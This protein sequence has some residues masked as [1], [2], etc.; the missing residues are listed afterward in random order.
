MRLIVRAVSLAVAIVLLPTVLSAEARKSVLLVFDEDNDLPGLAVINQSLRETFRSQLE[1]QVEFYSESL[2]LSQFPDPRH[3][4]VVRDFVRRKYAGTR[5]DL[6]VAVMAP[7][8][9]F[10]LRHGDALFPGVPIVFCGIDPTDVARR[11][12]PPNVTG[13]LVKRTFAPTL[14]IARR[15]QPDVRQV[16][17]V[18]GTSSF[19]RYVQAIARRELERPDVSIT[20]LTESPMADLLGRLSSL[21]P[22]S[23]VL[24]LTFF[25]DGTGR[26]F[27]PHEALSLITAAANAPVYVALD[28]YVGRGAVGGHVYSLDAHGQVAAEIGSRVLRGEP[29]ASIP[30]V[31]AGTYRDMFDWRQL[32]RWELDERRLPPGSVVSFRTRSV[33]DAYKWYI[34]GSA[35]LLLVQSALIVGL[36]VSRAQRRRAQRTLAERLQF[37]TLLSELSAELLTLPSAA[38]DRRIEDMLQRVV[39]TLDFDRAALAERIDGTNSMRVT[40]A[41]TRPGVMPV[42]TMVV[43][44][45]TL[46]W[47]GA[48][49]AAGEAVRISRV[50]ALPPEAASDRQSLAERG[51][52]SLAAV[53]LIV[54]GAVVGAVGFSRLRGEWAWPD[55]LMARLQLLGDVF[56]NVLARRRAESAVRDSEAR[57]RHAE[58]EARRQRDELAH[59]QRVATLGELMASIAHEINQPLA[60]ILTNANATRRLMANDDAKPRD[61]DEALLDIAHDAKR[62]AE[63]IRRLRALFL[64]ERAERAM[65]GINALIEEV[66]GLLRGDLLAKNIRVSFTAGMLPPLVADP[67]QLRQVVLNVV[68]NAAEAIAV[69]AEG[70]REMSIETSQPGTGRI[71]VAIRD[72]GVG[73]DEGKLEQI[74]EHFVSTKPEGLGMGLAISRSIVEAHGGR[75]WATCNSDRGLTIHIELPCDPASATD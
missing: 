72:S 2:N 31:E 66:L 23:I 45:D 1:G 58:E 32:Q 43:E 10:V 64:K 30:V 3:T 16:F 22:H 21:P 71:G 36:L 50:D 52:I 18:G 48:R 19:D 37:E 42:P 62:A 44:G 75:I 56:A 6:I 5:L 70:A 8:L 35:T 46:P 14:D 34:A 59:A 41:W 63:T 26:A 25:A 7:S 12:L 65:V 60:A 9:D 40:H 74:F 15:L 20:Y 55:E 33:W 24:Y 67:I 53:P 4:Q 68:V 47:I 73:V 28:Q 39:E 51:I 13:T 11:A 17:I 27:I 49:L 29:P 69:A 57:R 54:G 38:V 61:L